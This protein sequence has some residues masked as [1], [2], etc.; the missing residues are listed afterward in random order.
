MLWRS[1]SVDV[2]LGDAYE[3]SGRIVGV[4]SVLLCPMLR[5]CA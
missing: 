3:R 1:D 2:I 4:W 5:S